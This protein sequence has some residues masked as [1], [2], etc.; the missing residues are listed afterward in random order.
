MYHNIYDVSCRIHIDSVI[1]D[2]TVIS[3][4]MM[5]SAKTILFYQQTVE[6]SMMMMM[7]MVMMMMMII[8]LADCV[9]VESPR[10]RSVLLSSPAH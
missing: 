9:A 5:I 3:M 2:V 10:V 4:I 1:P 7:T 8:I 6:Q